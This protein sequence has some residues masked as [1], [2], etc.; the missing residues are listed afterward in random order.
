MSINSIFL[1]IKLERNLILLQTLLRHGENQQRLDLLE[2]GEVKGR[3]FIML[4]MLKK[5]WGSRRRNL[6]QTQ[7]INKQFVMLEFL[8]II[9]KKTL[10]DKLN[11]YI[12]HIQPH[13]SFQMLVRVLIS[14]EKVFK[15]FWTEFTQV[16]SKRLLLPIKIDCVDLDLNCLNGFL[17]KPIQNSWF[18]THLQLIKTTEQ[19]LP[20]S[21]KTSYLSQ[22]SS[23]PEITESDQLNLEN[24]EKKKNLKIKRKFKKNLKKQR[25]LAKEK[26]D[27]L[28]AKALRIYPTDLQKTIINQWLGSYRFLYNKILDYIKKQ[29][30]ITKDISKVLD[31]KNLRRLFINDSNYNKEDSSDKW[32]K[33]I[34]YD[35]RDEALSD[36]LKN[37]KSNF[38]KRKKSK[39][40]KNFNLKFKSKKS[41]TESINILSKH[42]NTKN[43]LYSQVLTSS[44]R[45]EKPLP[46]KLKYTCRLLKNKLNEYYLIIPD[47]I[48]KDRNNI[49]KNQ[50]NREIAMDMGIRKLIVGYDPS[51]FLIKIGQGD[52][53]LLY[54][55]FHHKTKLQSFITKLK[56]PQ[57][58]RYKQA[59]IRLCKRIQNLILESHRQIINWLCS[60]YNIIYVP[61]LDFHKFKNMSKK[62]KIK[63]SLWNHCLFVDRLINKSREFKNCTVKIVT[64]EF[65]SKTCCNCGCLNNNLGS[66]ETFKCNSCGIELDRDANGSVCI[67]LKTKNEEQIT[68]DNSK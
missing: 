67:Y 6:T 25:N 48:P 41:D 47:K 38:E 37:Y 4:K 19:E 51:G 52:M 61:K 34:P 18:S 30:L 15:P 50:V 60:N 63:M 55:L 29:F 33:T 21:Q 13:L 68:I 39:I 2:S 31:Q 43:S 45:S 53:S 20:N 3:D 12:R 40:K 54:R 66:S 26:T 64:E 23:L 16:L 59:Y 8:Q 32:L 5:S 36:L 56:G 46:T 11:C 14:K 10:I 58:Y 62:T 57:K 24:S 1:H 65:T 49:Y 44:I 7:F 27:E 35:I 17:K 42:W 9:K 28:S 22:I